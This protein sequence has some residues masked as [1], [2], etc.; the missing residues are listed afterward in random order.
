MP[1]K[2]NFSVNTITP[3]AYDATNIS[4]MSLLNYL[5]INQQ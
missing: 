2:V 4:E 1:N 3:S 5:I